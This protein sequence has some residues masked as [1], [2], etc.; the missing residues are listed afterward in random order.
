M[1]DFSSVLFKIMMSSQKSLP[2]SSIIN[3]A[4]VWNFHF[5]STIN[6]HV[7][8]DACVLS[9]NSKW[10]EDICTFSWFI[11]L[12]SL[13]FETRFQVLQANFNLSI[14]HIY[15]HIYIAKVNLDL[16]LSL[17]LCKSTCVCVV[18]VYIFGLCLGVWLSIYVYM[19]M[20]ANKM[21]CECAKA[22]NQHQASHTFILCLSFWDSFSPRTCRLLIWPGWLSSKP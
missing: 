16:S 2:K 17:H 5:F 21:C 1:G 14:Y 18:C 13:Y 11:L 15:V 4:Q 7:S 6:S 19:S 12:T 8:T 22:V 10:P 9:R 20:W 3:W